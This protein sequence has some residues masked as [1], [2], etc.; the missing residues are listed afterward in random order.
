MVTFYHGEFSDFGLSWK[1]CA[2]S[3]K[4]A[5]SNKPSQEMKQR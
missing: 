3:Q 1:K 2:G 5:V 4:M